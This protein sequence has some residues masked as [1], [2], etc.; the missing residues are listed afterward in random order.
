MRPWSPRRTI[1]LLL[2]PIGLLLVSATRLLIIS[3]YNTTTATT[4]ASSSGYVN[5]LLG[6]AIPLVPVFLPYVALILLIYRHYILSAMALGATALIAPT[7]FTLSVAYRVA[8]TEVHQLS[9]HASADWLVT[10][11]L[12]GGLIV[13][14]HGIRSIIF[15][16]RSPART[17]STVVAMAAAL[18]LVPYLYQ[19]YP[20][21]RTGSYYSAILREPWLPTEKVMLSSGLSYYGYI[22]S[23]DNGWF[24][25]LLANSRTIRYF[26]AND[27]AAQ[28]ACQLKRSFQPQYRP[29]IPLLHATSAPL[30]YCSS[31][32]T[33]KVAESAPIISRTRVRSYLSRGQ[34]ID[35]IASAV[36][37]APAWIISETNAIQR[38]HLSAALR[39]YEEVG[40]WNAP[41]PIGQHFWY[42]API[43]PGSAVPW[44][45]T[46]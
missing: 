14:I 26:A 5:T 6:T 2:S 1:G 8:R 20:V 28:V 38:Q 30:P 7:P 40:D 27:V 37:V 29:L 10:V 33:S 17:L 23:T 32:G 43:K 36:H 39:A 41:T 42:Y 34:S 15:Q 4:V 3:N 19:A 31:G 21:P 11:A 45:E 12:A 16:D 25:V 13:L 9:V 22:L 44:P 18:A 46:G 35:V 24:T